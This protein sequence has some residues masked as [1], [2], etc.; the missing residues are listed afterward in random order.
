MG[1][2]WII[3]DLKEAQGAGWGAGIFISGGPG[4]LCSLI[5]RV[6]YWAG[7]IPKLEQGEQ[8]CIHTL[9][10]QELRNRLV[11]LTVEQFA[12]QRG[13]D[14]N[15]EASDSPLYLILKSNKL[16]PLT[17]GLGPSVKLILISAT[18]AMQNG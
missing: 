14:N 13:H 7:G 11:Q 17:R 3:V 16:G 6:T 1:G 15:G 18:N 5:T 8:A 9:S 2:D 12:D 10:A 4:V